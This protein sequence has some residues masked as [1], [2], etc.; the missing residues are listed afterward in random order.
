MRTKWYPFL[1]F[2][3]LMLSCSKVDTDDIQNLNNNQIAIIGHGGGGFQSPNNP[4][5]AN[6]FASIQQAIEGYNVDGIEVDIQMS[7]DS[8]L[9]L[10][11]DNFL[12]TM[13][14]CEGCMYEHEAAILKKCR[15]QTDF[16]VNI[17]MDEKLVRLDSLLAYTARRKFPP[18]L[19][20]DIK[21]QIA[22]NSLPLN[23][24]DFL[25]LLT[26]QLVDLIVQYTAENRV[27]VETGNI[28]II[29]LIQ[30]RNAMIGLHFLAPVTTQNIQ[31]ALENEV[32]GMTINNDATTKE[33]IETAH[34]AGLKV[35][36]FNTKIR[37]AHI[38][39]VKKYPDYI[40]TDNILLLQQILR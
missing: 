38:D 17:F 10:Y 1:I 23:R 39:A 33:D 20:L 12:A 27:I 11:H 30:E 32:E 2:I 16:D 34:N 19:F 29:E 40:Q 8:V 37:Q 35:A 9:W 15:Y 5:P 21:D 13:T 6:S 7:A 26:R 18:I 24:E 4:Y 25:I 28:E 3:F 14:N 31:I 22:C 36:L